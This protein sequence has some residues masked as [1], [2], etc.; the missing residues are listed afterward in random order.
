MHYTPKYFLVNGTPFSATASAPFSVAGTTA[1]TLLR[2]LN[3]GL[4]TR[5]PV[6]QNEYLTL[7]ADDANP[8]AAP[9]QTYSLELAAGKRLDAIVQPPAGGL[10]SLHDRTGGVANGG[11]VAYLG[12]GADKIGVASGGAWFLDSLGNGLWEPLADTQLLYGSPTDQPLVGDWDGDG[13]STPG[14]KRGNTYYLRNSNTSGIADITFIYGDAADAPLVGDWDGNGTDTIGIKRGNTYYL[15]NSNTSGVAD[16]TFIYGGDADVPLAGDWDGNGTDTIGIQRDNTFYLRNSN[17]SGVADL[18]FIF[19]NAGDAA[20]VGDW[21]GDGVDTVGIYRPAQ[22]RFYLRNSNT[23]GVADFS[24]GF[25]VVNG[26]PL[27]GKW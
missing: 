18:A 25:G 16:I 19:G 3:A 27:V 17:T 7:I 10:L 13:V 12:F 8:L 15:R 22:G 11:M 4:R 21:D 9:S 14:V 1:P 6:L 5:V 2:L 24:P 20:I 26:T 23:T